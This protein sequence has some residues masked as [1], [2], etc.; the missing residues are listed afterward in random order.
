MKIICCPIK[1]DWDFGNFEKN[2]KKHKIK[3]VEAEEAFLNIP[4]V[5]LEDEKHSSDEKRQML[6]GRS[7]KGKHLSIIFTIRSKKIRIISARAMS[8]KERKLYEKQ[9]KI[10]S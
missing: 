6:L 9:A 8:R 1:F 2:Y 3:N 5:F 4:A 7:D 10:Y